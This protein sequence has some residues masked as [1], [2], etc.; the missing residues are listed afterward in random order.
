[1]TIQL[2]EILLLCCFE[3]G[4]VSALSFLIARLR[5]S[6]IRRQDKRRRWCATSSAASRGR[7]RR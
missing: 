7:R 3:A 6:R 1:V 5:G 4:K 2:R